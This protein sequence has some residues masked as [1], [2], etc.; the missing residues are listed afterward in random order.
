MTVPGRK[1]SQV[2]AH[3]WNRAYYHGSHPSHYWVGAF[4]G[5]ITDVT[6]CVGNAPP[7]PP[8]C[9]N[10]GGH[11][12]Y[13]FLDPDQQ[14][15]YPGGLTRT[16][17]GDGSGGGACAANCASQ[18]SCIAFMVHANSYCYIYTSD[19]T[20][21]SAWNENAVTITYTACEEEEDGADA[22][23]CLTFPDFSGSTG[24]SASLLDTDVYLGADDFTFSATVT[25][26][27]A[28]ASGNLLTRHRSGYGGPGFLSFNAGNET[29][30][31]CELLPETVRGSTTYTTLQTMT[32]ITSNCGPT[33]SMSIKWPQSPRAVCPSGL[34]RRHGRMPR[35]LRSR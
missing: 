28:V 16:T 10:D 5:A 11:T 22:D 9:A 34:L 7:P 30:P 31:E 14:T 12:G 2:G 26:G 27:D 6:L 17:A 19:E 15:N 4:A 8:P 18:D 13:R 32:L 1:P 25:F 20:F 35:L 21:A 29:A 33:R 23:G 24:T 3:Y